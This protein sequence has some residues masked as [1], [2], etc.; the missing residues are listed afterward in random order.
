ME[1]FKCLGLVLVVVLAL[2][3]TVCSWASSPDYRLLLLLAYLSNTAV[4][5]VAVFRIRKGLVGRARV[6]WI[7]LLLI[8][9]LNLY[10][11]LVR[12]E[13]WLENVMTNGLTDGP[14]SVKRGLFETE[15][16]SPSSDG[17]SP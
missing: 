11:A 2:L 16:K 1:P 15:Q 14:R 6:F 17:I 5:I 4:I 12:V 8:G 7:A 9:G 10:G 3:G 13:S